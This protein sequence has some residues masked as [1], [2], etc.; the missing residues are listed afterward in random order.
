MVNLIPY[1]PGASSVPESFQAPKHEAVERFQQ[2]LGGYS[3]LTRVR[4]EMGQDIAGACGQL[5]LT[6][7]GSA[8][9]DVED[10]LAW[11]RRQPKEAKQKVSSECAALASRAL[12]GENEHEAQ[13][14]QPSQH[15]LILLCKSRRYVQI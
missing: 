2:I 8:P 14:D 6:E 10:F 13:S 15:Q 1:N 11:R 3:I 7:T 4:R 9:E 12:A 5:A